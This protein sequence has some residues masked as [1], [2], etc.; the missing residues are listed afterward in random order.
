[1]DNVRKRRARELMNELAK[2]SDEHAHGVLAVG[3]G[4]IRPAVSSLWTPETRQT[5]GAGSVWTRA[6]RSSAQN[7]QATSL[8]GRELTAPR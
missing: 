4:S 2:D 6:L 8:T 7:C 5:D 1:M 3:E